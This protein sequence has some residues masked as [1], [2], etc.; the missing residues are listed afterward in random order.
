MAFRFFMMILLALNVQSFAYAADADDINAEVD[1]LN[2]DS[3][4]AAADNA[5]VKARM[6]KEKARAEKA[7][8]AAHQKN[9]A[10]AAKRQ[11]SA[12]QLKASDE[13][14]AALT[15]EQARMK[16]EVERLSRE[17]AN[18]EKAALDTRT[19]IEK[20]K[21]E[22][23]SLKTLRGE[24]AKTFIDLTTQTDKV[25]EEMKKMELEKS[26]LEIDLAKSKEQEKAANDNLLKVK[27]E[28]AAKKVKLEAYIAGLRERFHQAQERIAAMEGE[29]NLARVNG[30]KLEATAKVAE[31]EV[32]AAEGQ[33]VRGPSAPP[34][35][36]ASSDS[37]SAGGETR[38]LASSGKAQGAAAKT[39]GSA[40]AYVFKRSCKVFEQ[41]AKGANV[42][43]VQ[44]SG[45]QVSKSDEGKTWIAFQLED[46]RKGYAAKN[47]F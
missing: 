5:E 39:S 14:V 4:A 20:L 1:E 42:L 40:N 11:A 18:T 16:A 36:A 24:K 9:Q 32:I 13:E 22:I 43:M 3:D 31:N 44:K 8:R 2:A 28:E 25:L 10:A 46:G 27:A 7:L 33:L 41:P 37:G 29:A 23:E 19:Q 35:V 34:V 26:Q 21:A 47:C 38:G 15:A 12:E 6:A 17:T 30:Q 45:A